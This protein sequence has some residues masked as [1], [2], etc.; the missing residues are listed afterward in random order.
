[1][2]RDPYTQANVGAVRFYARKRVGGQVVLP[3][4]IKKIYISE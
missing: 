2:L 4:A 3:E 1:M